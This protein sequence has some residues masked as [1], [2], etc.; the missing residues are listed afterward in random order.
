[1]SLHVAALQL[2]W[3]SHISGFFVAPPETCCWSSFRTLCVFRELGLRSLISVCYDRTQ[4]PSGCW[5]ILTTKCP[6]A[7]LWARRSSHLEETHW[8]VTPK[9]GVTS[10]LASLTGL[11]DDLTKSTRHSSRA[12]REGWKERRG[13]N[14]VWVVFDMR[15][16]NPAARA[17]ACETV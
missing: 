12:W 5:R 15:V 10:D 13:G 16:T 14:L 9:E 4:A 2:D 8:S 7:I 17:W 11:L 1:M 6:L 3:E